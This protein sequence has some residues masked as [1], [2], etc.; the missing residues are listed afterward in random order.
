MR[1]TATFLVSLLVSLA[2]LISPGQADPIFVNGLALPGDLQD[3]AGNELKF[4]S[5]YFSD[6]YYDPNRGEWWALSDRGPGGGVLS[7]ATRAQRFTIDIHPLTGAI[8]K[9]KIVETV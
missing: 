3:R 7:Y 2:A 1:V 6:L 5:G 9:F 8:S 4:R